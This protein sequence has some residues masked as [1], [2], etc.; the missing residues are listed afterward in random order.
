MVF[1][2][3][4]LMM[5]INNFTKSVI[6]RKCL[7]KWELSIFSWVI[8]IEKIEVI[9]IVV[10]KS[11]S[12]CGLFWYKFIVYILELGNNFLCFNVNIEIFYLGFYICI[13]Y[14]ISIGW[15]NLYVL[16]LS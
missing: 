4:G 9:F 5:E 8:G 2:G 12:I 14:I 1:L 3:N 11:I 7:L 15:E 10:C 13:V 16:W 6:R